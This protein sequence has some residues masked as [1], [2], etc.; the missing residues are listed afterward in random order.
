MATTDE[1]GHTP[2]N[3]SA[4]SSYELT[5]ERNMTAPAEAIYQAWTVKFDSWFASP[6]R[7]QMRAVENE[8]F[9]F[10]VIH[11]G[12]RHP[13]YGRFLRLVPNQIVELTWV[14]GK[15]GTGG[16][17]TRVKIQLKPAEAGTQLV[18]THSGFYTDTARDQHQQAW[19]TILAHLNNQL[20][21]D[22]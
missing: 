16:A 22:I 9:F 7:I 5:I 10:E 15:M 18:L 8:P 14:T 4:E 19:P 11:E 1:P 2:A 6:G 20:V 13:H 12:G 3:P 17:E 21:K